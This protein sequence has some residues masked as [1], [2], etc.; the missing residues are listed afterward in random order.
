L[1]ETGGGTMNHRKEFLMARMHIRI[2]AIGVVLSGL[3]LYPNMS[4]AAK[5]ESRTTTAESETANETILEIDHPLKAGP[6]TEIGNPD[7]QTIDTFSI[8][9]AVRIAIDK[10][11]ELQA[12]DYRIGQAQSARD[13]AS[14]ERYPRLDLTSDVSQIT[15]LDDFEPISTEITAFGHSFRFR[16]VRDMPD[17]RSRAGLQLTQPL[18]AGGR[19]THQ[20]HVADEQ[21]EGQEMALE[22]QR[23]EIS[24]AVIHACWDLRRAEQ[25]VRIAGEAVDLAKTVSE[26]S[27]HREAKGTI[28]RLER[29]R[30]VSE[31][32]NVQLEEDNAR[33]EKT[34]AALVLFHQMGQPDLIG[35]DL[36]ISD[37]IDEQLP[38]ID[39]DISVIVDRALKSRPEMR[40][41]ET[42][43]R[44]K[45]EMI[46]VASSDYL[47]S[48]DLKGDY[49][50]VGYDE[51]R[52]EDSMSDLKGDYWAIYLNL[53]YNLFEGGGTRDRIR[54][55]RQEYLEAK[56]ELEAVRQAIVH[57]VELTYD[58]VNQRRS[59]VAA[60]REN[61]L[62][63]EVILGT[64]MQEFTL[65]AATV[66]K[67]AE[68]NSDLLEAR[69][70][71][72][73]ACTDFQ[74]AWTDFRWATGAPL[75]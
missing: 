34:T 46:R 49:Q 39:E 29:D 10:R 67:V 24:H 50:W 1:R 41:M 30:A 45:Q 55:A 37:K 25:L 59:M 72:V 32:M 71:Y 57:E 19:I 75:P 69:E 36:N 15:T 74:K 35:E 14:S 38:E 20:I 23:R 2:A 73:T 47:P 56:S 68:Y 58:T 11:V 12:A 5:E 65:G 61:M 51:D 48:V 43:V 53:R 7:G 54:K 62:L 9:E 18:Y 3:I 28:S 16:A 17:Y 40:Q 22:V 70:A 26:A 4:V 52:V 13:A 8:I 63:A 33:L 27:K 42:E 31:L 60:A 21:V 44:S 66:D 64:K 6:E